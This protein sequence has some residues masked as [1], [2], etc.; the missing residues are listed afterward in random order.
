[1]SKMDDALQAPCH[2]KIEEII[3]RYSG[4][5]MD[6]LAP[7]RKNGCHEAADRILS[8]DKGT[9]FLTTGFYVAGH[10]ETDGPVGTVVL[11]VALARLGYRP[12]ILTD[13]CC[14]G[15]FEEKLIG[16]L[17]ECAEEK[18]SADEKTKICE[19]IKT[20]YLGADV[21]EKELIALVD[22]YKPVGMISIERCGRNESGHYANMRGVSIDPY[23]APLDLLFERYFGKIP[24]IGVGD[25]GNEIGM[26]LME[27]ILRERG[28]ID[29]CV[30]PVDTL[31]VATVSNWGAYGITAALGEKMGLDLLPAFEQIRAYVAATV[32]CGSVDGVTHE[33]VVTVDGMSME[34]EAEIVNALHL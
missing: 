16:I 18:T 23:T 20:Y 26:G 30:I 25:G 17:S 6:L 1:M 28:G 4:R 22:Q 5:G 21:T 7:L 9:V 11:A 15:F 2:N 24:T 19:E 10:G 32:A 34:I 13:T 12:I 14:D 8:W 27:E 31:V 33:H 3:M 29:P